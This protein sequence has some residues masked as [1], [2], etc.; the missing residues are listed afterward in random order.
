MRLPAWRTRLGGILDFAP[1]P[2]NPGAVM[3]ERPSPAE[4]WTPEQRGRALHFIIVL[5]NTPPDG[6]RS[7]KEIYEALAEF[8]SPQESASD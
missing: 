5:A 2:I 7:K 6:W 4:Q 8:R 1:E 3:S